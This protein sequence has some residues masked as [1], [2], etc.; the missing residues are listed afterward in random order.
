MKKKTKKTTV[1]TRRK[2]KLV[3]DKL[4]DGEGADP[5]PVAVLPVVCPRC[6]S[7]RRKPFKDGRDRVRDFDSVLK[8]PS[9]GVFFSRIIY[10][11][12]EC[13]DCGQKM[14]VREFTMKPDD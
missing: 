11:R 8:E 9:L 1:E 13:L 5:I 7:T 6:K 12:T 3:D 4:R 10:R 14:I 2:P